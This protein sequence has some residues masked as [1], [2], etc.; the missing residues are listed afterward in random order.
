M[1]EHVVLVSLS[2]VFCC[3]GPWAGFAVDCAPHVSLL[4]F[5]ATVIF[6]KQVLM[7]FFS[8]AIWNGN[9]VMVAI[10]AGLWGFTVSLLFLGEFPPFFYYLLLI[11]T[12]V[13]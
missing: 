3:P 13:I 6:P 5:C 9:K 11:P 2:L 1:T 12:N 7:E 4:R 10:S 8:F